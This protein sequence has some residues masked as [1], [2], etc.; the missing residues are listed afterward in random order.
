MYTCQE[1]LGLIC[2]CLAAKHLQKPGPIRVS[3]AQPISQASGLTAVAQ[4]PPQLS[5]STPKQQQQQQ[6]QP[7]PR[8]MPNENFF[9]M[10]LQRLQREK[11]RLKREQDDIINRVSRM[12]VCCALLHGCH[13]RGTFIQSLRAPSVWV[14]CLRM[15][16]LG[17]RSLCVAFVYCLLWHYDFLCAWLWC[18]GCSWKMLLTALSRHYRPCNYFR[19]AVS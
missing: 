9:Q 7:P 6:Q 1:I 14:I 15:A 5:P 4:P 3:Q 18:M 10:E 11:E 17:K 19:R 8:V 2:V 13:A 16:I 12:L